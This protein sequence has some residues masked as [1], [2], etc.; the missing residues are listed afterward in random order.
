M[1]GPVVRAVMAAVVR[2]K[3]TVCQELSAGNVTAGLDTYHVLPVSRR[4]IRI[5]SGDVLKFLRS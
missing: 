1:T 5:D 4:E 3:V 2:G